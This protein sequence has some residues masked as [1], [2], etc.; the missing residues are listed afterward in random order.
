MNVGNE[1]IVKLTE[2]ISELNVEFT[3]AIA[4]LRSD[5]QNLTKTVSEV[6]ET[7]TKRLDKHSSELDDHRDRLV[8]L[9]TFREAEEKA[10]NRHLIIGTIIS[11]LAAAG[12]ASITT[13]LLR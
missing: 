2:S 9:E 11:T 7:N 3:K 10:R 6:S 8:S 4:E 13:L 1:I 5:L 12:I